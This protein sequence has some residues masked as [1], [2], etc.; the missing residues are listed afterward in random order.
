MDIK[1]SNGTHCCACQGLCGHTGPHSYCA[2]H[3]GYS[4]TPPITLTQLGSR[5]P[6]RCPVCA[7]NGLVANGFYTQGNMGGSWSAAGS[8]PET[9]RSC[10]GTGVVWG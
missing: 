1:I 10:N 3:S 2:L 9:C 4:Q 6:H 5:T 7:G 8:G